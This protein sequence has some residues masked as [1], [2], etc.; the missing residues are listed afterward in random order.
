MAALTFV[1]VFS[2]ESQDQDGLIRVLQRETEEA[3]RHVPGFISARIHGSLDGCRVAN[4]AQWDDVAAFHAFLQ[5]DRGR[6]MLRE[7]H[8]YTKD[9]DI[10]L[11]RLQSV[12]E[13]PAADGNGGEP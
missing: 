8:Q 2:C 1:N 13:P 9:I 11:Y 4:Y 10:H 7:I 5:G 3:V 12:H 6:R